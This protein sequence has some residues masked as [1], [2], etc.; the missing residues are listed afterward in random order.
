M[1]LVVSWYNE[2]E[3]GWYNAAIWDWEARMRIDNVWCNAMINVLG[4]G[5][6]NK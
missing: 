2:N 6:D 5:V 1:F 4:S 3:C